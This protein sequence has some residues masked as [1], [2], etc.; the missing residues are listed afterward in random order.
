MT[1]SLPELARLQKRCS[2]RIDLLNETRARLSRELSDL[3]IAAHDDGAD[4]SGAKISLDMVSRP[5]A[6]AKLPL[7]DGLDDS[8][9]G[10]TDSDTDETEAKPKKP[11]KA[12]KKLKRNRKCN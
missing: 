1:V 12:K 10:E 7:F 4:L 11:R 9:T 3:L 6:N 5:A 8:D 2:A